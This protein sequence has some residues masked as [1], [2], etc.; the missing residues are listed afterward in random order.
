VHP[1]APDNTFT[2]R[3]ISVPLNTR[4]GAL[5]LVRLKLRGA[6]ATL[7]QA[8]QAPGTFGVVDQ[9]G[10]VHTIEMTQ[11]SNGNLINFKMHD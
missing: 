5:S 2:Y 9:Y 6:Q 3:H 7:E 8:H 10:N 4:S 11:E 1:R